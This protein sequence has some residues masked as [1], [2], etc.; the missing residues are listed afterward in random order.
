MIHEDAPTSESKGELGGR[1]LRH[2]SLHM[3]IF[4]GGAGYCRTM[5]HNIVRIA[6]RKLIWALEAIHVAF[7]VAA[8]VP[9]L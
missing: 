7:K 2:V 9:W 4:L 8:V 1:R 5:S 3:T 6:L